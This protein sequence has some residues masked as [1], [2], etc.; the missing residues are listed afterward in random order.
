MDIFVTMPWNGCGMPLDTK[1]KLSCD[2]D[3]N[4]EGRQFGDLRLPWSDNS[5]PLGYHAIPIVTVANGAG[6]TLL[7]CGATH[8][9]EYEGPAAIMELIHSI[10]PQQLRHAHQA[11]YSRNRCALFVACEALARISSCSVK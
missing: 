8:G 4:A 6:P 2:I 7:L 11:G 1:T 5:M 10:D 9:D 3:L